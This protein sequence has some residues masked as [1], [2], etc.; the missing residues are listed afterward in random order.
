ML[1]AVD[2]PSAEQLNMQIGMLEDVYKALR[3]HSGGKQKI[4]QE[5]KKR[6]AT[7]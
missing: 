6:T 5:K 4:K 7:T 2:D 1:G 3:S